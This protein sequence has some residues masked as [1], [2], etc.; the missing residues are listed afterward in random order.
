MIK[1]YFPHVTLTDDS[2]VTF[3]QHLTMVNSI[4]LYRFTLMKFSSCITLV[5]DFINKDR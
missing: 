5:V 1:K 2:E 3:M 4:N